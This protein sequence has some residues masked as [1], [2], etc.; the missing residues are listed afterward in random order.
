V[1]HPERVAG[2][3]VRKRLLAAL[4]CMPF[5][6]GDSF[7]EDVEHVNSK[8]GFAAVQSKPAVVLL[9]HVR[10]PTLATVCLFANR[11]MPAPGEAGKRRSH[12]C[13]GIWNKISMALPRHSGR[14]IVIDPVK[15]R[16][17]CT[18]RISPACTTKFQSMFDARTCLTWTYIA[19]HAGLSRF[20][21][22]RT[23]K[24]WILSLLGWRGW[25]GLF[26]AWEV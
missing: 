22:K 7:S 8:R 1:I 26:A 19:D 24:D 4:H 9:V 6:L 25:L 3:L 15:P 2:K 14:G 11:H 5:L 20:P 12:V 23:L 13:N 10:P 18:V 21:V 16:V 17:R